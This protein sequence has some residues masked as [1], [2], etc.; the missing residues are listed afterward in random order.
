MASFFNKLFGISDKQN[1]SELIPEPPK[2]S[3]AEG[4]QNQYT[5]GL[6]ELIDVFNRRSQ[7]QDQFDAISYIYGPQATELR[8]NYGIDTDPRDIY[9]QRAGQLPQLMA[10]MN[11]RGLLDTGTSGILEGQMRSNLANELARAF[12]GAKTMQRQDID[13]SLS[14][15]AQLFPQRFQAQNIQ[16]QVDYDNALNSYNALL[17]RNAATAQG[18][19]TRNNQVSSALQGGL[20]LAMGGVGGGMSGMGMFGGTPLISNNPFG[21]FM[22]GAAGNMTGQYNP[23]QQSMAALTKQSTNPYTNATSPG[24]STSSLIGPKQK[25]LFNMFG[26]N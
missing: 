10:S 13:N 25:D 15:L 1:Y 21:S 12:G 5:G 2:F 8:Q 4:S 11:S 18:Q 17:S 9:S 6:Q 26:G 19:A 3:L 24:N 7:G 20:G 16:S 23:Y 22:A 14:A